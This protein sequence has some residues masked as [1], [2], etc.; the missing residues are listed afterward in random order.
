[1][2]LATKQMLMVVVLGFAVMAG[3]CGRYRDKPACD[4]YFAPGDVGQFEL[5]G[6]GLAVDPDSGLTWYRCNAGERF[7][8]GACTGEALLLS[9]ADADAYVKDF[10]Q[11]SGRQ[12][13]LPTQQEMRTL[14]MD[15]CENP[16]LNTNVFPSAASDSYWNQGTSSHGSYMAC[17][18][19]TYSGYSFCR[20]LAT[21]QRPF[22][23]ILEK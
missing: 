12:W 21:N 16:A 22:M 23:L 15:A 19:N 3:G 10:S 14:K 5:R 13:R 1:M 20:E 17:T 9:K 8:D 11:S 7:R 6:D 4:T 2:R 18:T